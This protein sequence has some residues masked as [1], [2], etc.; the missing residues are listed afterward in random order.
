VNPTKADFEVSRSRLVAAATFAGT[1]APSFADGKI[2]RAL[3]FHGRTNEF[4]EAS[5]AVDF[6]HTN[7]FSYGAWI[8]LRSTTGT[9][10][11]KMEAAPCSTC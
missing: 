2:G 11:S 6:E 7:A 3:S 9:V 8:Q 4:V 1:N 10:L 5:G